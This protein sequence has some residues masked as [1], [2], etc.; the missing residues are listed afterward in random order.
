MR[1]HHPQA[2]IQSLVR[3][4]KQWKLSIEPAS[5]MRKYADRLAPGAYDATTV[6]IGT[7]SKKVFLPWLS[8]WIERKTLWDALG[9]ATPDLAGHVRPGGELLNT[10]EQTSMHAQDRVRSMVKR[11]LTRQAEKQESTLGP[12]IRKRL[13]VPLER[14]N[15]RLTNMVRS[16]GIKMAERAAKRII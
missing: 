8:H 15:Y 11:F 6:P 14:A 3:E 9:P 13:M 12:A 2:P 16:F 4:G 5:A 1:N 10:I 7:R